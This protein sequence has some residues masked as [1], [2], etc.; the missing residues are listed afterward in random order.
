MK[1]IFYFLE[2]SAKNFPDK[3]C[4]SFLDKNYTYSTLYEY[5]KKLGTIIRNDIDFVN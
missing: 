3:I 4:V 2:N 1:N 5:S